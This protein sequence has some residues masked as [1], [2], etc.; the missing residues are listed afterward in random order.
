M[1][2][3]EII[4]IDILANAISILSS[5]TIYN[6]VNNYRLCKDFNN[7]KK[8]TIKNPQKIKA[9][10]STDDQ[11]RLLSIKFGKDILKFEKELIKNI[12]N[13]DLNMLYNNLKTLKSKGSIFFLQ[14]LQLRFIGGYYSAKKNKVNILH[15]IKDEVINHELLHMASSTYDENQ[16]ISYS[17][18][19]Q[20]NNKSKSCIGRALNEGYTELLN[21]RYFDG[22]NIVAPSYNVCKFFA[23]KLEEIIG[24]EEMQSAYFNANLPKLIMELEKYDS[25]KNIIKFIKSLDYFLKYIDINNS[26]ILLPPIKSKLKNNINECLTFCQECLIKWY[27]KQNKLDS[28]IYSYSK[29]IRNDSILSNYRL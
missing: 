16:K 28:D 17:G 8:I 3:N 10:F 1:K 6:A 24:K 19:C 18:F 7:N 21:D 20:F 13:E 25:Q 23:T 9:S 11:K 4:S 12:N 15:F 26:I 29:L 27:S 14:Y 22:C 5:L 2:D